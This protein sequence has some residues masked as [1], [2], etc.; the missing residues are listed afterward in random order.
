MSLHTAAE[1][2]RTGRCLE[3]YYDGYTRIVEVHAC[4]YASD[5]REIMRVWQVRGGSDGAEAIGWKLLRLDEVR[6]FVVRDEASYGPRGGYKRGDPA[7]DRI[8]F[9]L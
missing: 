5:G 1:A 2:A 9:Q 8:Y 6:G 3:I 4:G 7:M